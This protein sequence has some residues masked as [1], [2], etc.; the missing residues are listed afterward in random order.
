MGINPEG[1]G[2]QDAEFLASCG[3]KVIATDT[4]N[5]KDLKESVTKLKKYKNISFVLGKHRLRDF[6][7]K[8][9]IIRAAG[10]PLDS[11]YLKEARKNKIDIKADET[12]FLE[13]APG[14][15]LVGITGTKGKSTVTHLIYEILKNSGRRVFLAGNVRGQAALPLLKKVKAGD[16]VVMELDSWKLQGFGDA[17]I[18]PRVAV[19]TN[20]YQ[21]HLNYYKGDVKRY[22][23]DK[24][25][26]FKYQ[27]NG[28]TLIIGQSAREAIGKYYKGK[29][30]NDAVLAGKKDFPKSWKPIILGEH[31]KENMAL[32][33]KACEALGVSK[34]DIKKGVESFKGVSGRLELVKEINGVK[35]YNDTTATTPDATIAALKALNSRNIIL[36]AGGADKKLNYRELAKTI[37]KFVKTL[38]LFKGEASDKILKELRITNYESRITENITSMKDVFKIAQANAKKGD[39]ILLSPASASFGIFQNEFDRGE[40]FCNNIFK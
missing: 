4:K 19:F 32:A 1:R 18:S 11:V 28:D 24:S 39:I 30:K 22:F 20:F 26:I 14:I 5:E 37:P 40:Q 7:N 33:I 23:I 13:L 25:N 6:Q 8:D 27:K 2:V 29:I 17:K 15:A 9:L 36:I 21:D 3:A 16:I 10:A 35:Y 12:L 31:N 34:S 38:I